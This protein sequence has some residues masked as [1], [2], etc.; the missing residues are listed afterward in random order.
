MNITF[1][2]PVFWPCIGGCEIHTR[3]LAMS[4]AKEHDVT[5]ISMITDQE[6]KLRANLW[7]AAIL[8]CPD[9]PV[10]TR[11]GPLWVKRIGIRPHERAIAF[12]V[13]RT[14]GKWLWFSRRYLQ[15]FF[16]RKIGS[17]A[18]DTDI[19][20]YVHG[21]VSFLGL[22]TLTLARR[23]CRPFV[24]TPLLD[25]NRFVQSRPL[26]S[27]DGKP[28]HVVFDGYKLN[29]RSWHDRWWVRLIREAD[30]LVALTDFEVDALAHN[31]VPSKRIHR[32]GVGPVVSEGV[33]PGDFRARWSIG[34]RPVVLFLGRLSNL[35]GVKELII[36]ANR[37]WERYPE[38]RFVLVGPVEE[39]GDSFPPSRCDERIV[40]TGPLDVQEKSNALAACDIF[41]MPSLY[42]CLGGAYLEAW[43][44]EKPVVA[45]DIPTSRELTGEGR[46]GM[47]VAG[48]PDSIGQA[49]LHLLD[50]PEQARK[51]GEWGRINTTRRY[52]WRLISEKLLGLYRDLLDRMA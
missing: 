45:A 3:H 36:S 17:L 26:L 35:K 40:F 41:C 20:H 5:V 33:N 31:G 48:D 14:A 16:E 52:N 27:P 12:M 15:H 28:E 39:D 8:A 30:G 19:F 38:V 13:T 9:K 1:V 6:G 2:L 21:G 47:L 51:M 29:P 50:H 46:G 44:F 10:C 23:R 43:S 42:E 11:D 7:L 24:M 25:F 18:P 22:G 37:V 34:E 32:L 4:L 49:I